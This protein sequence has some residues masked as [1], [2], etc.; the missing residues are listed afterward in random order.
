MPQPSTIEYTEKL[1]EALSMVGDW[2]VT[3]HDIAQTCGV[4]YQ[5]ALGWLMSLADNGRIHR[6]YYGRTAAFRPLS[7]EEE[8]KRRRLM[9]TGNPLDELV[10]KGLMTDHDHASDNGVAR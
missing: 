9:S 7:S 6:R 3:A 5:T 1:L 2:P 8:S 4:H 10:A